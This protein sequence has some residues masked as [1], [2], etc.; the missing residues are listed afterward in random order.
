[1]SSR[2]YLGCAASFVLLVAFGSCLAAEG[3][4]PV[5]EDTV[6]TGQGLLGLNTGTSTCLE[7]THDL[8]NPCSGFQTILLDSFFSSVPLDNYLCQYVKVSG[9]DVGIECPDIGVETLALVQPPACIANL[10][11][12]DGASTWLQWP[13]RQ[14]AT[15]YDIIRGV[16]PGPAAVGGLVDLGAVVC[17]A[18]DFVVSP[19][20]IPSTMFGPR[21][22]DAPPIGQSF[23]YLIRATLQP[24][25][26]TPYGFSN[27]DEQESPSSGG[28]AP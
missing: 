10:S 22:G 27:K 13:T 1:M 11:V 26:V 17:V 25:G 24:S 18:D 5:S 8:T 23:F 4:P 21:D 28:C 7:G 3:G 9:Q 14:C 20:S 15:S 6:L 12:F 19:G 16:L 2:L